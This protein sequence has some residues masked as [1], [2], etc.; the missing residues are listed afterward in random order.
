MRK[1]CGFLE[2]GR[3]R[4]GLSPVGVMRAAVCDDYLNPSTSLAVFILPPLFIAQQRAH[5]PCLDPALWVSRL[6]STSP[7]DR[8]PG[9]E[10][11]LS[12]STTPAAR[13]I[14]QLLHCASTTRPVQNDGVGEQCT[15]PLLADARLGNIVQERLRS[16]GSRFDVCSRCHVCFSSSE[17]KAERS[18]DLLHCASIS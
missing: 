16:R 10:S 14:V 6:P 9:W 2:E 3:I 7:I 17:V 1:N 18:V 12:V 13:G 5:G 11:R 15:A 8:D 4:T